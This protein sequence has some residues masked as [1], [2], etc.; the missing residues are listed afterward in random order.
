MLKRDLCFTLR[1]T[2]RGAAGLLFLGLAAGLPK[3]AGTDTSS[4]QLT[5]Y[6][7]PTG[8]YTQLRTRGQTE[9]GTGAGAR[10]F[11]TDPNEPIYLDNDNSLTRF[12]VGTATPSN[13]L[14]VQGGLTVDR[15]I[16]L[17]DTQ[18]CGW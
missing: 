10:V 7:S 2:P 3:T 11:L 17:R 1:I 5:S 15:C 6:P 4:V 8:L 14:H 18:V 13:R 12:G 16:I 9:L